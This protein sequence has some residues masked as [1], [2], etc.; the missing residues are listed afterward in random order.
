MTNLTIY[1]SA[2]VQDAVAAAITLNKY[3]VGETDNTLKDLAGIATGDI[4]TYIGTLSAGVYDKIFIHVSNQVAAAAAVLTTAQMY[5]LIAKLKTAGQGTQVGTDIENCT[6]FTAT[7]IGDSGEAWEV[8]EHVGRWVIINDGTGANQ[9]AKIKSNTATVLTIDGTFATTPDATSD[10]QIW[11]DIELID[12]GNVDMI[13]SSNPA[14]RSW[15]YHYPNNGVP[16]IVRAIGK[17]KFPVLA[18][19]ASACTT[20]TLTH[21]GAFAGLD[22]AGYYAYIYSATTGAN[23]FAKIASHTDNALTFETAIASSCT[24]TIVYRIVDGEHYC[25]H[26]AIVEH[27]VY[28]YMMDLSKNSVIALYKR[29]IDDY[30]SLKNNTG[31]GMAGFDATYWDFE[32]LVKGKAMYDYHYPKPLSA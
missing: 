5:A 20:T 12:L 10:F 8:D 28:A 16:P 6:T 25:F 4:T 2:V 9:L 14:W 23:Q 26:D 22:L 18:G 32:V 1:S 13:N 11:E 15:N 31:G 27:F 19:T 17:Y 7:T 21:T 24:G 3:P 29:L 30:D